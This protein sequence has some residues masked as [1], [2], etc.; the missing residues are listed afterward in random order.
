MDTTIH[1]SYAGDALALTLAARPIK[2]AQPADFANSRAGGEG[3][4]ISDFTQNLEAHG[5]IV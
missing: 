4:N 2:F 1:Q 5:V 3:L